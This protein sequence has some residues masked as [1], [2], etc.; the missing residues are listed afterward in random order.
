[1]NFFEILGIRVNKRPGELVCVLHLR[2]RPSE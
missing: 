1:V 2:H